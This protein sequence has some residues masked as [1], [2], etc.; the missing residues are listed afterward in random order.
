MTTTTDDIEV[1]DVYSFDLHKNE[2]ERTTYQSDYCIRNLSEDNGQILVDA[3]STPTYKS[4][5]SLFNKHSR[6]YRRLRLLCQDYFQA[7]TGTGTDTVITAY[8]HMNDKICHLQRDP[9]TVPVD[10]YVKMT[11]EG[12]SVTELTLKNA[13]S[14][15]SV[16]T[17]DYTENDLAC[18]DIIFDVCGAV[19]PVY[20]DDEHYMAT[21][22]E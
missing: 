2:L 7:T 10:W 21:E 16:T 6:Y 18:W 19:Y 8:L 5:L 11:M 4:I 22:I 9:S 13:D 20:T 17:H 14:D 1:D 15:N 12:N 3:M